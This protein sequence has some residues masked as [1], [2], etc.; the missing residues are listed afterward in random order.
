MNVRGNGEPPL[1][2]ARKE[3]RY[4][5]KVEIGVSNTARLGRESGKRQRKFERQIN[6]RDQMT[7][8][9]DIATSV[10]FTAVISVPLSIYICGYAAFIEA[11]KSFRDDFNRAVKDLS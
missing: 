1:S 5:G 11:L 10:S 7:I 2:E 4:T 8:L 9:I 3:S 6:Q